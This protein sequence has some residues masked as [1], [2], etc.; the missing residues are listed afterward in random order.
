[1][2]QTKDLTDSAAFAAH[3]PADFVSS[4]RRRRLPSGSYSADSNTEEVTSKWRGPGCV[5]K[6][7]FRL[8]YLSHALLNR[9]AGSINEP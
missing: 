3:P 9:V 2:P 5:A 8:L 6:I 4:S 1:M 7:A